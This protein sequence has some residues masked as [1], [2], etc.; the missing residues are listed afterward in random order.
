MMS[1]LLGMEM[2]IA[3]AEERL[4]FGSVPRNRMDYG[5]LDYSARIKLF[6]F[7]IKLRFWCFSVLLSVIASRRKC[8]V[9][10]MAKKV[11]IR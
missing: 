11:N 3:D 10:P 9:W 2:K 7:V 6:H 5:D 8:F 4:G 1:L